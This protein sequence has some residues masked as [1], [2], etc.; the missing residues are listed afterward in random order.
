MVIQ[1]RFK[2]GTNTS[3][4]HYCCTIL[5]DVYCDRSL[6]TLFGVENNGESKCFCCTFYSASLTSVG[7][8]LRTGRN[9]ALLLEATSG[10]T[11]LRQFTRQ[12][13]SKVFLSVR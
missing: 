7:C 5:L 4:E 9:T 3:P 11:V 13:R 1:L 8:A 6:K 12:M 10:A 2:P